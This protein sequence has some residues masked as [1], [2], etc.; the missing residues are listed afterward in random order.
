MEQCRPGWLPQSPRW[1]ARVCNKSNCPDLPHV[2]NNM[3]AAAVWLS[4]SQEKSVM[5]QFSINIQGREFQEIQLGQPSG[6]IT[7]PTLN[8]QFHVLKLVGSSVSVHVAILPVY[9]VCLI[10]IFY[11]FIYLLAV[12]GLCCCQWAFSSCGKWGQLF[13]AVC[14]LL[15]VTAS[16]VAEHGL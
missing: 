15:S 9:F 7:K 8:V 11:N 6:H 2:R 10:C 12:L 1:E 3:T 14:R 4:K 16:P 5:A 13:L